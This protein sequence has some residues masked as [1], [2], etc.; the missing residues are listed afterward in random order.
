LGG[1][2]RG[3]KGVLEPLHSAE[4]LVSPIDSIVRL[5]LALT[6]H[7]LRFLLL[8]EPIYLDMDCRGGIYFLLTV[9]S[10]AIR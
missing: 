3:G 5:T 7:P 9:M 8:I 1:E 10:E 4:W 2:G 6:L